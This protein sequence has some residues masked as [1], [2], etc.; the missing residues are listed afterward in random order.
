MM[1]YTIQ[2]KNEKIDVIILQNLINL[3][4]ISI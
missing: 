2:P 1:Y 3:Q 4:V